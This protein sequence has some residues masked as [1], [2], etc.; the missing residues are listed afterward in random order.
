MRYST[1]RLRVIPALACCLLA[2]GAIAAEMTDAEK[3][4]LRSSCRSDYFSY[5]SSVPRGPAVLTCL[6]KNIASVSPVCRQTLSDLGGA[7]PPPVAATKAALAPTPAPEA[8]QAAIAKTTPAPENSTPPATHATTPSAAAAPVAPAATDT[9]TPPAPAAPVAKSAAKPPASTPSAPATTEPPP[10][11]AGVEPALV[12][13][14]ERLVFLRRACGVDARALCAG[15]PLGGGRIVEC[16][17]AQMP[18]LSPPCRD[19]LVVLG[20]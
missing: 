4:A 2:G 12:R 15:V 19:A 8:A 3:D 17:T 1:L 9:A 11:A 16:L 7:F 6:Q 5:C 18:S 10:P 20:R 14:S 13:P